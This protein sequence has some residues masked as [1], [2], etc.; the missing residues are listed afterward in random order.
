ML[1]AGGFRNGMRKFA[2]RRQHTNDLE[3]RSTSESDGDHSMVHSHRVA[4]RYRRGTHA[5]GC[6]PRRQGSRQSDSGVHLSW[7]QLAN[8]CPLRLAHHLI[9]GGGPDE[10]LKTVMPRSLP[11]CRRTSSTAYPLTPKNIHRRT[12]FSGQLATLPGQRPPRSIMSVS[13]WLE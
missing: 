13:G 4:R 9:V 3:L 11:C 1:A 10:I 2:H 8:R 5:V 7:L 12:P 6:R